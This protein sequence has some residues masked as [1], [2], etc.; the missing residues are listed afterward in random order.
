MA[1]DY[2]VGYKN[3]PKD[4]QFKKGQSGNPGG[5]PKGSKNKTEFHPISK[6]SFEFMKMI[7]DMGEIEINIKKEGQML[8]VSQMEALV[9]QL[10]NKAMQGDLAAAK[11]LLEYTKKSM[12]ELEEAA[13][14]AQNVTKKMRDRERAKIFTPPPEPDSFGMLLERK[15]QMYSHNFAMREMLGPTAHPKIDDDEPENEYQWA[16]FNQKMRKQYLEFGK[17]EGWGDQI[18]PEHSMYGL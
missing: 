18:L 7:V 3:P 15:H 16:Q 8:S 17:H 14:R 1:D 9:M 11:I 4:S 5:R 13:C 10:Y 6:T 12:E 2:V